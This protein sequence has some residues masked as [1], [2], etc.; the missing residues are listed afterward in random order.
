MKESHQSNEYQYDNVHT[1]IESI[2]SKT[3]TSANSSKDDPVGSDE[4]IDN[5]TESKS[6]PPA[7]GGIGP[8]ATAAGTR[9][10]TKDGEAAELPD[11][12]SPSEPKPN[13][14]AGGGIAAAAAHA[15][16]LKSSEPKVDVNL[17]AKDGASSTKSKPDPFAGGGIA[18]MVAAAAVRKNGMAKGDSGSSANTTDL[19]AGGGI[20]AA[21]AQAAALKSNKPSNGIDVPS[22]DGENLIES[23]PDP[24]ASGGIAAMAAAAAAKKNSKT[25]GDTD[26]Y[27]KDVEKSPAENVKSGRTPGQDKGTSSMSLHIGT[28]QE[29]VSGSQENSKPSIGLDVDLFAAIMEVGIAEAS[30]NPR[31][32]P[33][34]YCLHFLAQFNIEKMSAIGH[35]LSTSSLDQISKQKHET[36]KEDA[37][38][39]TSLLREKLS[40]SK[41]FLLRSLAITNQATSSGMVG[42]LEYGSSNPL[43]RTIN[44]PFDVLQRLACNFAVRGDWSGA[45]DVLSALVIRCEQQLPIYHPT[46]LASM[47]DLAASCM[48]ATDYAF[49]QGVVKRVADRL[50]LY[51]SEQE[52]SYFDTLRKR[53]AFEYETNRVCLL[54]TGADAVSML[55]AFVTVFQNHL[56]REFMTLIGPNHEITLI[57][58]AFVGDALTVLANCLSAGESDSNDRKASTSSGGHM[59]YWSLAYVHYQQSFKGWIAAHGLTHPN[60]AASAYSLARCLRELG[61]VDKALQV[62]SSVA[63]SL[64]NPSDS[65]TKKPAAL[66]SNGKHEEHLSTLT[67]LPPNSRTGG[68]GAHIR[69]EVSSKVQSTV[70]CL[71]M[72]AV[73]SVEQIPDERGRFRA[74]GLLRDASRVLQHALDQA[75]EIDDSSREILLELYECVEHEASS[76]FEPLERMQ[77]ASDLMHEK[78]TK[79]QHN[80][81]DVLTPMR[82]K[83]WEEQHPEEKGG[84]KDPR[85]A[86]V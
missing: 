41:K 62:L 69:L 10:I 39:A 47:L 17:H 32:L 30:A 80:I 59:Y 2:L 16:A 82:R 26:S 33:S 9:N 36:G 86:P 67:F 63:S 66:N 43:E 84:R 68:R 31:D 8:V 79:P 5:S 15:A 77:S 29:M 57:N 50:A 46:T 37:K 71:W 22:K 7:G 70:L 49:A 64:G 54:D 51:L 19:F 83:R 38:A 58:Q 3:N 73:F 65:G 13:P 1:L 23:K 45:S 44:L 40:L 14:F 25:N 56:S 6:D 11:G 4:N 34:F 53:V 60:A 55:K 61:K 78:T 52:T 75:G 20:A 74:L 21:A 12:T 81:W 72:T 42:W 18:A 76:L 85:I 27:G 35:S 24:S 48:M 28:N